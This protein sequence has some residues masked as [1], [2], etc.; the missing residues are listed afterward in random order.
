VSNVLKTQPG[1]PR[2]SFVSWERLWFSLAGFA[3]VAATFVDAVLIQRK[4]NI[5]T[6]GFLSVN[7][8][9]GPLQVILFIAASIIADAAVTL[10][11]AGVALWLCFQV[12]LSTR[13][14]AVVVLLVAVGPI[15][16]ANFLSYRLE[17]YLGDAFNLAL[18]FDLT[19]RSP[20]EIMAVAAPHL[21]TPLLLLG[22]TVVLLAVLLWILSRY[23]PGRM[24]LPKPP[25]L[26]RVLLQAGG[27]VLVALLVTSLASATSDS[28]KNGLW[29]KPSGKFLGSVVERLSDV[30][31]DGYGIIR[32]PA[33]PEPL[34]SQ[35]FPYAVEVP[36]NGVDENGVGGD[37]PAGG[38]EYAIPAQVTDW[39]FRPNV[40]LFVLESFRADLVGAKYQGNAVTP[41]L[42]R[43]GRQGVSA[44]LAFSHN[45]YTM[46]SRWHVFSGSVANVSA[47]TSLID[48]FKSN[49]YEVAYF[50]AQDESF[51]E[52]DF[53]VG[54]SRAHVSYDARVEPER[55]YTMFTTPGSLALPYEVIVERVSEFLAKRET[56][57]PLFLYVNF[58]ETH[59]PYHHRWIRPLVNNSALPRTEIKP[60]RA[61]DLWATY[62]NTAANVDMAVGEVL[63]VVQR[64]LNDPSPGIIVTADHGESLFE[65][66]FL[67]HGYALNDV[68]TRIPLVVVNLPMIIE[69]PF[70]QAQ[71]RDTLRTALEREPESTTTPILK[72]NPTRFVFQYLGR[73]RRPRQIALSGTSGR[74]IYDFR[75]GRVLFPGGRWQLPKE[76][77][78]AD[79]E[80]FLGLVHLWERMVIAR[81]TG[82]AARK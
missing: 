30:D 45:G 68:Q 22:G 42:D 34:N 15:F 71:L 20:A 64:S 41:V 48:D 27:F 33:D 73:F 62:V 66:G 46:E 49:G 52:A 76:L 55:R 67:G 37:L 51:G 11:L 3:A 17:A 44:E 78:E 1:T 75:T 25:S 54:F 40:I 80:A 65:E 39:A 7:H 79:F 43:L 32:E 10:P 61:E 23:V 8:L 18:M 77:G 5:F 81:K 2:P 58:H 38:P 69:Q 56:S 63:D 53:D 19:G 21:L 29:R 59:F 9:D 60:G 13:V 31:R 28:L 4:I 14:S 47:Q 50:S 36:G 16:A 24:P 12:P 70:G 72:V 35:V 6:G 57:R 26:R 74:T 82:E